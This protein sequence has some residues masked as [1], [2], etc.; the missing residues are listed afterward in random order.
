M[1]LSGTN[2]LYMLDEDAGWAFLHLFFHCHVTSARALWGNH[3]L[4]VC[5]L[6]FFVLLLCLSLLVTCSCVRLVSMRF[7]GARR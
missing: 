7:R 4:C 5:A 6:A 3:V 1:G 2:R